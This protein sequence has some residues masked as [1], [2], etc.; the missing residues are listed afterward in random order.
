MS[1]NKPSFGKRSLK[2]TQG[3]GYA[4]LSS[5]AVVGTLVLGTATIALFMTGIGAPLGI[6]TGAGT[7]G[8]GAAVV[9]SGKR[10][11]HKFDRAFEKEDRSHRRREE[12]NHLSG[13]MHIA[14]EQPVVH[15]DKNRI[16]GHGSTTVED[17]TIS[18]SSGPFFTQEP[19][20][21]KAKF[22]ESFSPSHQ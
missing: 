19:G 10:A 8:C 11:G 16:Q 14:S 18:G 12:P 3:I 17:P 7:V 4:S 13:G 22:D 6:V 15:V 2:F 1:S 5:A 21:Q 9:F 20:A